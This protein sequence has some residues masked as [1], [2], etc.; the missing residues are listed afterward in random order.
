MKRSSTNYGHRHPNQG[1][2][3]EEQNG[4]LKTTKVKFMAYSLSIKGWVAE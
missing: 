1:R 3:T 2:E 4:C